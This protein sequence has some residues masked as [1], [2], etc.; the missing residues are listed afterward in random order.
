[1]QPRLALQ[2][3]DQSA[4]PCARSH[5]HREHRGRCP[6]KTHQ[7]PQLRPMEIDP[8]RVIVTGSRN[9]PSR[10]MY[11]LGRCTYLSVAALLEEIHQS[12]GGI[13]VLIE[14]GA[15]GV[16]WRAREWA[17]RRGVEVETHFADW[18][19]GGRRAGPVRNQ[20][21]V[22]AGAELVVAF[23]GGRGTAD[24]VRRARRAGLEVVQVKEG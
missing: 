10:P 1:M 11:R 19:N 3:L 18:A 21:M 7:V 9:P 13:T 6:L 5:G 2:G 20:Q 12:R 23:P 4:R 16:D 8:M 17:Q 24:C 22:D 14:G 15:S